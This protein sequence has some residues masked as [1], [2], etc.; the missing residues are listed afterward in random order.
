MQLG[1]AG[2]F[3]ALAVGLAICAAPGASANVSEPPLPVD[4]SAAEDVDYSREAAYVGVGG[5]FAAENFSHRGGH[6]DTGSI[7]FRAGYR[8][9]PNVAVEFLGEVLPEFQ[10]RGSGNDVNGFA[11]T[12]NGKLLLPLGRLEPYLIAGIGLLDIDEDDRRQRDDF[13]FR[14]GVGVDV[15]LSPHWTIY[16]EAAYLLPT[17]EVDD[18]DYATVGGGILFRF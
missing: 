2:G 18:Y 4:G 16:G 14:G 5:A 7:L 1:I 12:V 6:D 8:G 10:G 15:H 13:A 17:G 3:A 11:V 9:L